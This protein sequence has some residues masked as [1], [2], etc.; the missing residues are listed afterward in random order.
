MFLP[1]LKN[2]T[3]DI[4]N[5]SESRSTKMEERKRIIGIG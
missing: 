4:S 5:N 1:D 3:E 2:Q